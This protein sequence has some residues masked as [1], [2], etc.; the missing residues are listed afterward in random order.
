MA[1]GNET[2][3]TANPR[4]VFEEGYVKAA[5]TFTPGMVVLR[6]ASV[7]LLNGK[8]TYKIYDEG[9]DGE[10]PSGAFW[11]VTN[12][13]NAMV[14][15][16]LS[17]TYAAG[18]RVSVYSPVAGE[19]LNLLLADIAGT[20]DDHPLGQKL[21][22]DTGTGKLIATTGSPETEVAQLLEVVTDPVADTPAWCQW[23]GH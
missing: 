16:T 19:E 23:S 11:V 12:L 2:I 7:A 13:L 20:G 18:T 1:R 14:G 5:Q 21:I 4:G 3:V 22:V 8:H 15:K 6:D 17:D 9:A 10:Q